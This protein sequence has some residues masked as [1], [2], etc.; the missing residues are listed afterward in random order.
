MC[1]FIGVRMRCVQH[2]ILKWFLH[3]ERSDGMDFHR[4]GRY[5]SNDIYTYAQI[6]AQKSYI[7]KSPILIAQF[8]AVVFPSPYLKLQPWRKATCNLT[9]NVLSSAPQLPQGAGSFQPVGLQQRMQ[10][11]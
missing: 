7:W 3:G 11:S 2:W 9:W 6:Y 5:I 8:V 10:P 4:I 1:I